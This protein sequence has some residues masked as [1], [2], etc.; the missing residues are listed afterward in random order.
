MTPANIT[1]QV[2]T[3]TPLQTPARGRAKGRSMHRREDDRLLRGLGRF[4]DDVWMHRMGYA[5]FVRSP[6]AHA[7]IRRVDTSRAESQRGVYA[8]LTGAEVREHQQEF[9]QMAPWPGGL[10]RDY[11]L[12]PEKARFQGEP[13]AV[14]LADSREAARDAAA[15]V[16]VEYDPLPVVL[17]VDRALEPG[18]PLVHR[19]VGSNVVWEG[20]YEF[21]DVDWAL[22]SADNVVE[23]ER[24]HFHRFS[25]TP[26]ECNAA[27]V[28]W[29][30]GTGIVEIHANNQMPT[31]CAQLMGPALGVPIDRLRFVSQDIGG[32][33]GIKIMSYVYITALALLSR[34]AGRPVKWTESR[35]EHLMAAGHGNERTFEELRVPVLE[36]GTILG[37]KCRAL[38]DVGAYTRY[39]PLGAVIWSQVL[40]GPYRFKHVTV[41]FKT[42]ATNRCPVTPNRG[43]SRNQHL[44]LIERLVDLCAHELGFDPVELRKRN[45]IQPDEYPYVTPNGCVHDSGDLPR[46]LD[47]ALA[48]IDYDGARRMQERARADGRLV[49][50]GIGS[51]LDSG[52]SN[53]GQARIINRDLPY[54]GNGEAALAKLDLHGEVAVTLGTVPQGQGH[55]TTAAQVVADELGLP[56]EHV[57]VLPGQD[58]ARNVY[59]GWSGTYA[60][61]FAV[62]GLGAAKGAAQLLRAEI[63][64]VAAAVLRCEEEE[65]ALSNGAAY[66]L[67]DERRELSFREVANYVYQNNAALPTDLGRITLNCRYHYRPPFKIPDRETKYGELTLTYASQIHACVIELDLETGQVEILDYG[68]V[69]ECGVRINPQIVDGQVHGATAHGIGAA[70]FEA[71]EYDEQGQLRTSTFYDYHVPTALDMPRIKTDHLECP[72][73]V[74]PLGAKGMGEGGGAPVGTLAAAIQDALGPGAPAVIDTHHSSE[75]V[76][77]MIHEPPKDRGVRSHSRRGAA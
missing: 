15:L 19:E 23:V 48:L 39:E 3:E 72:S 28:N 75:A 45:Y 6:Y 29:D 58:M 70:L 5:H 56:A 14:V 2:R 38:D 74:T 60:S 41:D 65:L 21:G 4:A 50:I 10:I 34:K 52:T 42:V 51:T 66:V 36:D 11:C 7:R 55:E 20:L 67:G 12:A 9:D 61:Q 63:L 17:D 62:T 25:S 16:R 40:T 46:A 30:L 33:F 54:S 13:V 49:G 53:F 44:F 71:L 43:Y 31:I 22:E 69:D 1:A 35:S 37:F 76:W 24:L 27:V 32:A 57:H 77:R 68:A 73:P 59:I 26:I 64:A 18:A 8:T 47:K